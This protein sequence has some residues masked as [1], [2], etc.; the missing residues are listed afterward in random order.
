MLRNYARETKEKVA[1]GVVIV[2][3]TI[4]FMA[5]LEIRGASFG[6]ILSFVK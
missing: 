6:F 3:L 1:M 4:L 2:F 5:Y